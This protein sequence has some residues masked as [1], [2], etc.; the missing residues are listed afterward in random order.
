MI[1]NWSSPL[2]LLTALF[3]QR[4]LVGAAEVH[5]TQHAMDSSPR[6][7]RVLIS[8]GAAVLSSGPAC[9]LTT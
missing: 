4:G 5:G 2:I 7:G 1:H 6:Q 9:S 8:R 3:P